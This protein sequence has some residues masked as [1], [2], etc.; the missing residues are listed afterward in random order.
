LRVGLDAT[1]LL[2]SRTGIGHAVDDMVQGMALSPD[3]ELTAYSLSRRHLTGLPSGVRATRAPLPGR[4]L[5]PAWARLDHPTVESWT[6]ALDLVHGPNYVVPPARR[7]A[8]VVSVW[9]MTPMR[10]PELCTP[11]S[12]R[13]P[14]LVRRALQGGAWIHTGSNFVADELRSY[15]RIDG[16]RVRVVA[17]AVPA[18]A[19]GAVFS[20]RPYVLALGATEPRK[21]LPTLVAAFD[22]L[23]DR[24]ADLE[25]RLAGPPGWG[26]DELDRAI[27]GARHRHRIM[28]MGWV[29][30][31]A[32]LLAG[33]TV[34]AYPSLYEGF[35][36]PPLEAMT[37]G[38]PVVATAVGAIPEVTAG[39]A[40]LVP[41]GDAAALADAL[42]QVIGDDPLRDRLVA[43]GRRRAALYSRGALV[44]GLICLYRDAVTDR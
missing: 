16:D 37:H 15:Y 39:A 40:L 18:P 2:G 23:G 22:L 6:G 29:E 38:V 36:L 24:Y 25:L 43:L 31:K 21:D 30:D 32:G 34:L 44:A 19:Q 33:A 17:P 13:Y 20:G 10:F 28:K 9:D 35:G 41:P 12:L 42:G 4:L 14:E 27:S 5:V 1:Q 8:R 3:V 26:E 7:A 11:S